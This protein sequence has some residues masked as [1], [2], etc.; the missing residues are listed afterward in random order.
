MQSAI[1]KGV[2]VVTGAAQGIG[3]G[4]ALR[5]AADGYN[6]A[7]NDHTS[8]ADLLKKVA[9]EIE[10]HGRTSL[11]VAGDISLEETVEGM[12]KEVVAKLGSLD[13]VRIL[14]TRL[15]S[16]SDLPSSD[17]CKCWNLQGGCYSRS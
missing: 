1:S 10:G 9:A 16:Y 11:V 5:L 3:R 12:V 15:S 13:V 2:A 17:D 14:K 8:K 6:V 4:I 7:I